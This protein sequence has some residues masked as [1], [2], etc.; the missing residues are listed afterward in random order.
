MN[1]NFKQHP[2]PE[3][4]DKV[5]RQKSQS[6]SPSGWTSGTYFL[7]R[8]IPHPRTVCHIQ[9]LNNAPVCVVRDARSFSRPHQAVNKI[10]IPQRERELQHELTRQDMDE[11][12]ANS[13]MLSL[14]AYPHIG[15]GPRRPGSQPGREE[16][17]EFSKRVRDSLALLRKEDLLKK[18][19]ARSLTAAGHEMRPSLT[20]PSSPGRFTHY[21]PEVRENINYAPSYLDQE[22]KVLEK[23]RDILQTDSLAEIQEW[24]SR[25]SIREKEFVSNLIRSEMT[26][27]DLLNYQQNTPKEN[28]VENLNFHATT[29]LSHA[30]WTEPR[31]EMKRLRPSSGA[32]E[33]KRQREGPSST[34]RERFTA[35][36]S[37]SLHQGRSSNSRG[38]NHSPSLALQ[39][40][41]HLRYSKL[42]H[43]HLT[44][45][46]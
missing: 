28:A 39:K 15:K 37:E 29:K 19:P 10:L 11:P 16:V 45:R 22:I 8:H 42:D 4:N 30:P 2:E 34:G 1:I 24:L 14:Q 32:S 5:I 9:G 41:P 44:A 12:S 17:T 25:A 35:P 36:N 27:R 13:T 6:E 40:K 18:P 3:F 43:R 31:E 38:I 26:S 7:S 23:L 33:T 46:E 20:C 21:K